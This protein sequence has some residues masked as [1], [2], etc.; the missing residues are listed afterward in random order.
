MAGLAAALYFATA[1]VGVYLPATAQ[2]VARGHLHLLLTSGLDAAPPVPA[3][4]VAIAA[5]A[6]AL[7][8]NRT[9]ACM[10]WR[11]ALVGH[12]GSALI[13][14]AVIYAFDGPTTTRDY[15]VSCVLGATL[16]A[17]MTRRGDRLAQAVG[18][19]GTIALLPLSFSWLGIEHPLAIA[20]GAAA[21]GSL[22]RSRTADRPSAGRRRPRR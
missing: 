21:S 13:A 1:F 18:I 11:V 15:G 22:R 4:Q 12:V 17:L 20:L 2:Q 10:W 6:A 19:A 7:L 16:G 9:D 5:A 3:L 14:Y 8:I